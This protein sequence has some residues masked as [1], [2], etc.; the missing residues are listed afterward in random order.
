MLKTPHA[1]A[2]DIEIQSESVRALLSAVKIS[3]SII[4]SRFPEVPVSL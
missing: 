4:N 1:K 2:A 3:L